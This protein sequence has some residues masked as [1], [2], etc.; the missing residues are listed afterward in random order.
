MV[1]GRRTGWKVYTI[2]LIILL[3]ILSVSMNCSNGYKLLTEDEGIAHFSFEYPADLNEVEF[4]RSSTDD[5]ICVSL[6]RE[7]V[8]DG[9]WD[10][11]LSFITQKPPVIGYEEAYDAGS[12]IEAY[13]TRLKDS[14]EVVQ[15]LERSSVNISGISGE[16]VIYTYDDFSR[17]MPLLDAPLEGEPAGPSLIWIDR[18]IFFD[19]NGLVWF[20]RMKST[21]ETSEQTKLDFE[22]L[23]ET[24]RILE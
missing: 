21:E 1:S 24:F 23:T 15:V 2:L 7:V 13:I 4:I 8:K 5:F 11:S 10:K 18:A 16:Q 3:I 14:F 6:I 9:W 17:R 19:Y 22:H 20:I 12:F